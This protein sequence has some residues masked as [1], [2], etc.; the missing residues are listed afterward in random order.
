MQT[1]SE[2]LCLVAHAAHA[3]SASSAL[4]SSL[5]SITINSIDHMAMCAC[6]GSSMWGVGQMPMTFTPWPAPAK[7]IRII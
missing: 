7:R 4:S 5:L 1:I 2:H 6:A 3:D